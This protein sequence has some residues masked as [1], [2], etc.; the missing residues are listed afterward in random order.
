MSN[1]IQVS[2]TI[3]EAMRCEAQLSGKDVNSLFEE[4]AEQLFAHRLD[5]NEWISRSTS[6]GSRLDL[7]TARFPARSRSRF[8][9]PSLL[10]RSAFF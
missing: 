3:L 9:N 7:Y 6:A 4:A 1:N 2:E 5:S 10:K 8:P